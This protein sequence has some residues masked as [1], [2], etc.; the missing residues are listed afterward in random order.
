MALPIRLKGWTQ[1]AIDKARMYELATNLSALA[2]LRCPELLRFT[3]PCINRLCPVRLSPGGR[4]LR[5][6][7][8]DYR[9][10][11]DDAEHAKRLVKAF[12]NGTRCVVLGEGA[13]DGHQALTD[14]VIQRSGGTYWI[15]EPT[16]EKV[17]PRLV[18]FV[19]AEP[20][21]V[22]S[23]KTKALAIL[24]E[25]PEWSD[26][27]IACE[28]PCSRTTLYSWDEFRAAREAMQG[29]RGKYNRDSTI[30]NELE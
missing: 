8:R 26:T 1:L 15:E 19:D 16:D 29:G 12:Q 5:A 6:W 28:V 21:E 30:D 9:F 18:L 10:Q 24:F 14:G 13:L 22:V 17:K 27:R 11:P 25:H 4:S 2:S 20:D 3:T 23:K 7:G